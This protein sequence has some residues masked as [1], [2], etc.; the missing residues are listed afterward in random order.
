[1]AVPQGSVLQQNTEIT[2]QPSKT[3]RLDMKHK[4]VIGFVDH[5]DAVKQAVYLILQTERFEYLIFSAKYGYEGNG[6]VGRDLLFV[7]SEIQRRIRESLL[8]DDRIEEVIDFEISFLRDTALVK[9]TVVS[10]FGE[11]DMEV[12]RDV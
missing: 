12:Q 9:F 5:L 7:K 3:Y 1:M 2:Q 6:M 4:R 10:R 8:Q 11:F